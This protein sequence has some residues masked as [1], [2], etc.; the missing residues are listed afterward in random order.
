MWSNRRSC[1]K[2]NCYSE[3][4][5]TED[6][7]LGI[8]PIYIKIIAWDH[9][10]HSDFYKSQVLEGEKKKIEIIEAA[11]RMKSRLDDQLVERQQQ[12]KDLAAERVLSLKSPDPR[13]ERQVLTAILLHD[14]QN[15]CQCLNVKI[16][17]YTLWQVSRYLVNYIDIGTGLFCSLCKVRWMSS[18][19]CYRWAIS[20]CSYDWGRYLA[21]INEYV[22][23]CIWVIDTVSPLPVSFLMAHL[24]LALNF[25]VVST[26]LMT[27]SKSLRALIVFY[28]SFSHINDS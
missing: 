16:I 13:R 12:L 24:L 26:S 27:D 9:F 3:I 8:P 25:L 2:T 5:S 6:S 15:V 11:K 7:Q 22:N 21:V 20:Q 28:F 17:C 19:N 18:S 14:N 10:S 23:I 4:K 1:Q